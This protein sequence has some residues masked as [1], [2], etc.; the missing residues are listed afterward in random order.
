MPARTIAFTLGALFCHALATLPD[1]L[2][3]GLSPLLLPVALFGA[4]LAVPAA[5][6]LGIAW[7]ALHAHATLPG[8]LPAALHGIEQTL[9]G[10]VRGVPRSVPGRI[11][12]DLAVASASGGEGGGSDWR[13]RGCRVRLTWYRP[14]PD[15]RVHAGET[16]RVQARLRPP[17][18]LRN[19]GAWDAE[20]RALREGTCAVGYLREHPLRLA[21]AAAGVDA[22]RERLAEG[23]R[24]R[25]GELPAA[26]LLEA[27]AVGV[28]D[29]VTREQ[30]IVLQRTGTAHLMAIS[31]LHVG[32]A[33]GAGLTLGT[34]LA[35]VVPAAPLVMPAGHWGALAGLAAAA[36][37][38]LLAG[39]SVP[40]QRAL[41]MVGCLLCARLLRRRTSS[42]DALGLALLVVLIL[43][44][45]AARDAGTWLSFAA[46]AGL[47]FALA[48][49]RG[50][51]G[52]G[53]LART[54][55]GALRVQLAAT[56]AL[57]PLVLVIFGYQSP[58]APVA[59]LLAVPVTGMLVVPLTLA[60]ALLEPFAPGVAGPLLRGAAHVMGVLLEMLAR[61]P[62]AS[63]VLV[64]GAAPAALAVLAGAAG[65]AALLSGVGRG[66]ALA[67]LALLAPLLLPAD[68]GP[69]PGALRVLVPDVGQGLAVVLRTTGH[70]LVYDAGPGWGP[71]ADAGSHVLAP[72]LRRE[73]VSGVD[74]LLVSHHHADH[75]GGVPGLM[76]TVEVARRLGEG[77]PTPCRAG[78]RWSWDG[79]RFE[80]LHPG[81]SHSPGNNA[82]CVLLVSGPGGRLLLPGDVEGGVERRLV[83]RLGAALRA[84]VLVVPHH[85][86]ASSSTPAFLDAVRP[87][88][89]IVSS[90]HRN[91]F[92]HPA[93]VVVAR[94]RERGIA[95][96]DTACGGL[97]RLDLAPGRAPVVDSWMPGGLRFWHDRDVAR[98]CRLTPL[99]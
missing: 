82:S 21:P 26:G 85:G 53:A 34:L 20:H 47:L 75:A 40:T 90:G 49:Q 77:A 30:R 54:L 42:A 87:R 14:P 8:R 70:T 58:S 69:P 11:G 63:T 68:S 59:N 80:I 78:Q 35:R 99:R 81:E 57:A 22:L 6:C 71:R 65:A 41:V 98:H 73:G 23:V 2:Y 31:G 12:F 24:R 9:E 84:D 56:L 27:L 10:T 66:I 17:R 5:F 7:T 18:G 89:A 44:P 91:R 61:V 50:A 93:P 28:R 51:D 48:A 13:W 94:Y 39:F 62:G 29:G 92:R 97:L 16:W 36:G 4:R 25:A 33:A 38:A 95:L 32:L 74:L 3:A 72:A 43:D 88:V 19:P 15:A 76:G 52:A 79:Y 37:Y 55:C 86:S 64:P 1:A 83:R 45:L 60:G 96:H 46:A 67:G